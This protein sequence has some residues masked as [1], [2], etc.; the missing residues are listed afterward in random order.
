MPAATTGPKTPK[1][2]MLLARDHWGKEES[3]LMIS[4]AVTSLMQV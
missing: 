1:V 4:M 2:S 3:L